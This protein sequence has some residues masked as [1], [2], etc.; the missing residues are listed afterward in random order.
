MMDAA[1]VGGGIG[2]VATA[3]CLAAEGYNVT[4]FERAAQLREIG[5]G[6][7]LKENSLGVLETLGQ[8][9]RVKQTGTAL[10]RAELWA[11]GGRRLLS[12][13]IDGHRV[14]V[15]PRQELHAALI[16]A[17]EERGVRFQTDA[18]VVSVTRKGAI[19]LRDGSQFL[20]N[21]VVGADG[22][23]SMVRDSLGLGRSVDQTGAGSWRTLVE[24]VPA[25]PKNSV[26]E[27]W[28]GSRRVLVV[29]S[30]HGITYLCAS[31]RNDDTATNGDRFVPE[32]WAR[33][34][35]EFEDLFRRAGHTEMVRREHS[36]CSVSG[37][38]AGVVAIL[39]DAVHGQP[40]NLG[41]GAGMAISNAADLARRVS[42][43]ADIETKLKEWET[44]NRAFT[45][46]VQRWSNTYDDVVHAWPSTLQFLRGPF[47]RFIGK[48]P[49]TRRRWS[50]LGQ[51]LPEILAS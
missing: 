19:K 31:S 30:G 42:G 43:G 29:P 23:G 18:A 20:A 49:P 14:S 33:D 32:V 12:R 40:P 13:P 6:I 5:A 22:V 27:Y 4:V 2:G 1:V 44:C 9:D 17:A 45:E 24:S 25:D 11:R 48:F 16:A 8:I 10:N 36:K 35:P 3:A 26:I 34:F 50:A 41:Q 51:G 21:L 7:F 15:L 47:V 46:A 28:N 38:T 37:W 39:G